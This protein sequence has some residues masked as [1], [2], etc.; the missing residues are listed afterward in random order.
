MCSHQAIRHQAGIARE[1]AV[2]TKDQTWHGNPMDPTGNRWMNRCPSPSIAI[3]SP[4]GG[5]SLDD[6]A[7]FHN[8]SAVR[9]SD[10]DLNGAFLGV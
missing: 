10:E 9:H 1:C 7:D 6:V 3:E 5:Y 2:Y 8:D 4:A